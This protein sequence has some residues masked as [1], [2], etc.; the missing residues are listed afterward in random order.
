MSEHTPSTGHGQRDLRAHDLE[1]L[2]E[3]QIRGGVYEVGARLPT[4]R[5]LAQRYSVNKNTAA[6]A[7]QALERRGLIDMSRGRGA[8]ARPPHGPDG[9]GLQERAA[10]LAH[11]AR[12]L[13]LSPAQLLEAVGQAIEQVYGPAAPRLL[14][15]ECNRADLE[16][17]GDELSDIVG[18]PM[19]L[20]LL[21]DA[22]AA[23]AAHARRYDLIVTT[24]QHLGQMRQAIPADARHLVV[25]VHVTPTHD[26]LLELARLHVGAFGLVCDT[27][28]TID[29]LS[30]IIAAY[31]P[32]AEVAPALID[33]E[34]QLRRV[35]ARADAIVVTRSCRERLAALVRDQP[36]ITVV[37]TIDQQSIDFLR[38]R[39]HELRELRAGLVAP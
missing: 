34:A 29:S 33:D 2:I 28:S 19:E 9:P 14:F 26:T 13:G 27:P 18:A 6:R 23:A 1:R 37:F 10:Q 5:E 21:D 3:E 25:G 38:R 12:A 32:A 4:V 7:Y 36:L 15:V 24:F 30:H 8:F 17:L 22:V 31:N 35:L 20:A 11:E 39:L 16:A